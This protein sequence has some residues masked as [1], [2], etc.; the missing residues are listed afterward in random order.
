LTDNPPGASDNGRYQT[1]PAPVS[2]GFNDDFLIRAW[3]HARPPTTAR[4]YRRDA[5]QFLA[6]A[7]KPISGV[8]LG[9]LQ[10]WSDA[11]ARSAP[12]SRAR[13]L[14]SVRSLLAF[15]HRLGCLP[16]DPGRQLRVARAPTAGADRIL[17]E[18]EI[19]RLVGAEVDPRARAALRL[20]YFTGIRNAELCALRRRD[21]TPSRKGGGEARIV[22][23]G[24]KVRTVAV[25]AALW[26]ELDELQ[27]GAKADAPVIPARDGGPI[28]PRALHR[29]VRR[30]ARRAGLAAVSPHWLRHAHASHALDRGAAPHVVQQ[31]LGHASLATT[32]RYLH[33][34]AGDSSANYLTDGT[35]R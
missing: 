12:A 30:A 7:G 1:A 13:R 26:R 9:D 34:R 21:L 3:L 10:T 16:T 11:L 24:S 8:V 25:P 17:S 18:A 29:L 19:N 28:Q 33:V 27:P 15:G 2:H 6:H 4:A 20:L 22:G 23:K 32:T 14:A 5:E 35:A 31:S